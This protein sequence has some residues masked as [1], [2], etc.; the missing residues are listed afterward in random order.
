[1]VFLSGITFAFTKAPRPAGAAAVLVEPRGGR[2][3]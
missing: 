1:V 3:S 2:V